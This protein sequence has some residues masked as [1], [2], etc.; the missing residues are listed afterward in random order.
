MQQAPNM[1]STVSSLS[2]TEPRLPPPVIPTWCAESA[3][4]V[5][6]E[7][8]ERLETVTL[9]GRQHLMGKIVT[10]LA[11]QTPPAIARALVTRRVDELRR[12]AAKV[13]PDGRAFSRAA[14]AVVAA[15]T[16]PTDA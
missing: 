7:M 4:I 5:V 2:F 16:R 10:V 15:M 13:V 12:E 1:A 11:A 3:L 6:E 9:A 14:R 8:L